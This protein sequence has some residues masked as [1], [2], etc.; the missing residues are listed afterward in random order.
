MKKTKSKTKVRKA[1][2][3]KKSEKKGEDLIA[4]FLKKIEAI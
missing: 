3:V 4:Y 1:K 2:V